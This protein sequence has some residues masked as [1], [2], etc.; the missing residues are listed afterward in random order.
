[1]E[2]W[3]PEDELNGIEIIEQDQRAILHAK[4]EIERSA[5]SMLWS[6]KKQYFHKFMI[7]DYGMDPLSK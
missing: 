3:Q 5:D 2:L 7:H 4:N 1:M 6:G